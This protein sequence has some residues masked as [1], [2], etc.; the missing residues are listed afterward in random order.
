MVTMT[1][2]ELF[3][4]SLFNF[5]LFLHAVHLEISGDVVRISYVHRLCTFLS[6]VVT[7]SFSSF[8]ARAF[9]V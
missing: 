3:S 2:L 7:N 8:P 4:N 5:M 1:V 9:L 6:G